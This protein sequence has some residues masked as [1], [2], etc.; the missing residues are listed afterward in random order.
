[1]KLCTKANVCRYERC[2]HTDEVQF[3]LAGG[4]VMTQ[5]MDLHSSLPLSEVNY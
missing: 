5:L 3:D 4:K 2:G 1:M